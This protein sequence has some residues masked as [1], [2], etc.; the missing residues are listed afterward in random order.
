MTRALAGRGSDTRSAGRREL[1]RLHAYLAVI[2][3]DGANAFGRS[4]LPRLATA[5]REYA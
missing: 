4:F 3:A 2:G 1:W 5:L